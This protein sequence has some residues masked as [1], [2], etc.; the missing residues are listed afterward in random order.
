MPSV[1]DHAYKLRAAGCDA[2][3]GPAARL[4]PDSVSRL[5]WHNARAEFM[6]KLNDAL[7]DAK[8]DEERKALVERLQ[9]LLAPL[10]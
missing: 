1:L 8:S 7:R 4:A 6:S 3:E 2:V 5:D 10:S 9:A